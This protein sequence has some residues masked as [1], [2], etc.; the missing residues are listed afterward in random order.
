MLERMFSLHIRC[1]FDWKLQLSM[2]YFLRMM[3]HR[4]NLDNEQDNPNEHQE[5]T[6]QY[7]DKLC[8]WKRRL[9][10]HFHPDNIMDESPLQWHTKIYH[11]FSMKLVGEK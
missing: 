9:R 11:M 10:E 7:D 1:N 4:E 5:H 3:I 2:F 6:F 8:E